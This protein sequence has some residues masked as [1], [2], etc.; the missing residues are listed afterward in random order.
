MTKTLHTP[1]SLA[2][3]I[4]ADIRKNKVLSKC[5]SF[6]EL[7]EHCDAN[8]LGDLEGVYSGPDDLPFINVA[9]GLVDAQLPL[10]PSPE[11]RTIKTFIEGAI[12]DC[13]QEARA[14]HF[15]YDAQVWVQKRKR[16]EEWL[17]SPSDKTKEITYKDFDQQRRKYIV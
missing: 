12:V 8:T 9:F 10:T 15:E 16:Y 2:K 5:E 11:K 4:L 6:T 14:T 3:T 13:N 17:A 1:E 7:H